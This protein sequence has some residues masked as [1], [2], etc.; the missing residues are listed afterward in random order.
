MLGPSYIIAAI[1]RV[2]H[3]AVILDM[4][5]VQSFRAQQAHEQQQQLPE[6]TLAH[7]EV[8]SG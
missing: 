6:A 1:D 5:A 4:T 3:H 2:V 7:S 8:H